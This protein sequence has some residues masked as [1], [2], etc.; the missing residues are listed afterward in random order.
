MHLCSI[1]LCPS[2]LGGYYALLVDSKVTRN[3]FIAAACKDDVE[4]D[5]DRAFGGYY[6]QLV[7]SKVYRHCQ[8]T[9]CFPNHELITLNKNYT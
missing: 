4:E 2:G 5:D 7:E 3:D 6:T 1:R 9:K 8:K